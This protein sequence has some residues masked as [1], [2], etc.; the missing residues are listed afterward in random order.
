MPTKIHADPVLQQQLAQRGITER[1]GIFGEHKVQLG[2]GSPIRLDSIKGNSIPYQ[3]FRTAT[4]VAR[5]QDGLL[6]SSRQTLAVLAAPEG[7]QADKLLAALKT[8]ADY[9]HRLGRLGQLSE[10]QKANSLWS[11]APAVEELSNTELAAVYQTFTSAEMDLLQ[12]ALRREGSVNAKAKDARAAA[13]QLFDL[14]ALVLK[15]MSNRVSNGRLDDLIAKEGDEA[16]RAEYESMRP[17]LLS[18]QYA[19]VA[20]ARPAY[21]HDITAGNLHTLANVAAESATRREQ[22][23]A[24]QAATLARRG[25]SATPK[26]VGDLLRQSPL[27]INLPVH[28]LMRDSSFV[29]SPDKPMPNIFHVQQQGVQSK[30]ESYMHQRVETEHLLF[31]ELA[32]HD[33]VPDERPVY[34]ALNTVNNPSGP[35]DRAYGNCLIVLKP[36]VARRSTFIAEDSFF[37]PALRITPEKKTL[38]YNILGTSQL[39]AETIAELRDPQS[40]GHQALEAWLDKGAT[41]PGV[42]ALYLKNPPRVDG[43]DTESA[44]EEFSALALK[45]FGD[46]EGTRAKMATYE[47]LESL[48]FGLDDFNGTLLAEA[49]ER[50]ANGQDASV[51]LAMNYIEAQVQGPI[52]PARDFQELRVRLDDMGDAERARLVERMENFSK[53]TGVKVTYLVEQ[54]G[55]ANMPTVDNPVAEV[56]DLEENNRIGNLFEAGRAYYAQ[57]IRSDVEE[58]LGKALENIQDHLHPLVQQLNLGGVFPAGEPVLRGNILQKLNDKIHDRVQRFLQSP[59]SQASTVERFILPAIRDAATPLLTRKAELLRELDSLTLPPDGQPLTPEQ[60]AGLSYWIRSSQV[61][62]VEE[63]RMVFQSA[64]TQADALRHIAQANPPLSADDIFRT[65]SAA[66]RTSEQT[67]VAYSRTL[68]ADKEYGLDDTL[69]DMNRSISLAYTLMKNGQPPMQEAAL[70]ELHA[71]L[72]TP[73]VRHMQEQLYE[74]R[75]EPALMNIADFGI[76]A[77]VERMLY[78]HM[79]NAARAVGTRMNQSA[80]TAELSLLP[81]NRRDLFQ[82]VAPQVMAAFN[83]AHPAYSPFPAAATPG[84]MPASHAERRAFIARHLDVYKHHEETFD[85]GTFYHGRGHVARAYIFASAM[86]SILEEQ[87]IAVDRNAVLCGIT[88]HDAGRQG[89]GADVWEEDSARATVGYMREDFGAETLGS[90]YEAA[91]MACGTRTS[92]SLESMIIKSADSLDIGRIMP[93]DPERMPFLRGRNGE[94]ISPDAR[95]LRDGLAREAALLQSMSNPLCRIRKELDRLDEEVALHS[96]E[97]PRVEEMIQRKAALKADA[98]RQFASEWAL[99]GATYMLHMEN[100]VR[101]HPSLFPILSVYYQ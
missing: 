65:L 19:G 85:R 55:A 6:A 27:T 41:I 14:E 9:M 35:A 42:T 90:D 86:C 99:D 46:R 52:I 66:S 91:M 56:S 58:A 67:I 7:L 13:S 39:P 21:D 79:T 97:S 48:L 23:S 69:A 34:G 37:S 2:T 4:K 73:E 44:K 81:Q 57:H 36:E 60:K 51:R 1:T 82:A 22:N 11:L 10:A 49:A 5:G 89:N 61:G 25:I 87:G 33:I 54:G 17:A 70:Q 96:D 63:L 83:A 100:F 62:T 47:N 50:R 68:P 98:A 29:L 40:E 77:T 30:G 80:Y 92:D 94:V 43:L 38:F 101:G 12:A 84:A 3:G 95:R 24:A 88:G 64:C 78:F 16:T 45:A 20:A 72:T 93:F 74:L 26:D 53:N 18:Q 76:L 8:N 59:P 32:E 71:R 15:E 31:P 28:R 75:Q